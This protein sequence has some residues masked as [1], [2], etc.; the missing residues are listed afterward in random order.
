[1]CVC[2]YKIGT[3][4][5]QR[6]RRGEKKGLLKLPVLKKIKKKRKKNHPKLEVDLK[7]SSLEEFKL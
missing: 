7:F 5:E 4:L 2:V 6:K 3:D 1:M